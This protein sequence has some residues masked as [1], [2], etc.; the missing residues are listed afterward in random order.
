MFLNRPQQHHFKLFDI[1][2]QHTFTKRWNSMSEAPGKTTYLTP[3]QK[4]NGLHSDT[5]RQGFET[6]V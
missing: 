6:S 1:N 3:A 5:H 2:V 4:E